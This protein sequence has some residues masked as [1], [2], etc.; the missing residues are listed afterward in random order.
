MISGCEAR[1]V[2]KIKK[3][4]TLSLKSTPSKNVQISNHHNNHSHSSDYLCSSEFRA[5][6]DDPSFLGSDHVARPIASDHV[7]AW[8]RVRLLFPYDHKYAE[9]KNIRAAVIK[10]AR[11]S[12]P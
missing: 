7:R 8:Y 5:R 1:M 3:Y 4:I 6:F 12:F 10:T 2:T 11:L 9:E